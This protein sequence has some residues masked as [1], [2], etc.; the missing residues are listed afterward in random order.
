MR[1]ANCRLGPVDMLSTGTAGTVYVCSG[2]LMDQ[3]RLRWS[4]LFRRHEYGCERGMP[5]ITR[6]EWRFTYQ[7]VDADLGS[8]PAE[9]VVT[10]EFDGRGI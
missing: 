5:P 4:H 8:Q 9:C 7:P 10:I 3:Y 2:D 1:D 6:V